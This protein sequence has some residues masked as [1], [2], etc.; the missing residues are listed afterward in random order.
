MLF[1]LSHG[2]RLELDAPVGTVIRRAHTHR[3]DIPILATLYA[4]LEPYEAGPPL[5]AVPRD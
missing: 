2:N 5:P 1:D 4:L 3:V